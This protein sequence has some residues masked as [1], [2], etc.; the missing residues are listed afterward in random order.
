M[1][2]LKSSL[3]N[4]G[5]QQGAFAFLGPDAALSD[6]K[7]E[8]E[9]AACGIPHTIVR[10]GELPAAAVLRCA[11]LFSSTSAGK[12]CGTPCLELHAVMSGSSRAASGN[13]G[14]L[15][16]TPG[17]DSQLRFSAAS[18]IDDSVGSTSGSLRQGPRRA[19]TLPVQT[20]LHVSGCHQ[21][22]PTAC[23]H[24]D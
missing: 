23:L 18:S 24:V 13:A 10:A 4:A 8:A 11:T 1:N 20:L 9:V 19:R 22:L 12:G 16:D 6:A 3:R 14:K 7:Q 17:G 5:G 21:P 2:D 15:V